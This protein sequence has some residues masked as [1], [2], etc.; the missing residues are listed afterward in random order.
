LDPHVRD[1]ADHAVVEQRLH[2]LDDRPV[3]AVISD[4]QRHATFAAHVDNGLT[5]LSVGAHRLFAKD[6]L[7]HPGCCR[8]V[9]IMQTVRRG[10]VHGVYFRIGQQRVHLAVQAARTMPPG[11]VGSFVGAAAHHGHEFGAGCLV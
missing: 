9:L 6:R 1:P 10:N 11:E 8:H 7:A 3:A 4:I 5:F 2:L